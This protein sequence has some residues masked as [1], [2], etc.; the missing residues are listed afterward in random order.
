MYYIWNL[1]SKSSL[2]FVV[3]F[4]RFLICHISHSCK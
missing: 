4:Y 3:L 2:S 1:K